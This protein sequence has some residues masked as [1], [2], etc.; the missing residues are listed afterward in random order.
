MASVA[1]GHGDGQSPGRLLPGRLAIA[2]STDGQGNIAR[3]ALPFEPLVKDIVF[4]RSVASDG[5]GPHRWSQGERALDQDARLAANPNGAG[6]AVTP[7]EDAPHDVAADDT[8]AAFLADD[9]WRC[10]PAAGPQP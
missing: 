1:K 6:R 9:A 5:A 3:L 4:T 10:G 8:N 7:D 2:F